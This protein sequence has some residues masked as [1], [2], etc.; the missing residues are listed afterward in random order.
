MNKQ[1]KDKENK[2]RSPDKDN[3]EMIREIYDMVG[4]V[5]RYTIRRQIFGFLKLFLIIIPLVLGFLY[6]PPFI[7]KITD[8]YKGWIKES[9]IIDIPNIEDITEIK[10]DP[11]KFW[12]SL[13]DQERAEL[14]DYIMSQ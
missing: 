4:Y 8:N 1:K 10:K 5:K 11:E 7:G 13:S 12:D 3:S 2:D 9:G 6:L 14:K